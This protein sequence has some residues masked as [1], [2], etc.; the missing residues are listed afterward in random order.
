[1]LKKNKLLIIS[2]GHGEDLVGSLLIKN[3]QLLNPQIQIEVLPLVGDGKYYETTIKILGP[4]KL[5]PGGGFSL[6][7]LRHLFKDIQ[8]GYLNQLV[9]TVK[10]LRKNKKQ[11]DLVIAIGDIIPV[12]AGILVQCPIIY[13]GINKSA[14]YKSWGFNYLWL[15]KIILKYC[16]KKTFARDQVTAEALSKFGINASYVGNPMMDAYL[17]PPSFHSGT[18]L[19][20]MERGTKGV[21]IGFLPG[22]RADAKLNI[23]DFEKIANFITLAP[24]HLGPCLT[25]RQ[26]LIPCFL[27]A[28]KE[29]VAPIFQNVS[30]NDLLSKADIIVGLSGTGNEQAAGCGI[31]IVSFPG[32]GSQYNA[33]F[34]Q[35][36]KELLGE[37][38]KIV[39][40]DP[41]EVVLAIKNILTQKETYDKISQAGKERMG[42]PGA[43]VKIV[44]EIILNMEGI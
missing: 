13:L 16:V 32:R 5:L 17:T 26:A 9:Q 43:I 12:L 31:P 37:T 36:Q 4:R 7:N 25:G 27:I 18:P 30:F 28:T 21:R 8:S 22:T 19:H 38:L 35:A 42:K 29:E 33:K 6:R 23:E 24:W 40:N 34:A 11:Y 20:S 14:Y 41:K 1:M 10:T 44:T 3:L 15:E 2:N 39:K